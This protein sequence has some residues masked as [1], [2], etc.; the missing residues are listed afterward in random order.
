V[1]RSL[2]ASRAPIPASMHHVTRSLDVRQ[3]GYG[4]ARGRVFYRARGRVAGADAG[5]RNRPTRGVSQPLAGLEHPGALLSRL[6]LLAAAAAR[7]SRSCEAVGTDYFLTL[8]IPIS[9]RAR[10]EDRDDGTA[11]PLRS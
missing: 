3:N 4:E 1:T 9:T 5:N 8:R 7:I 6:R 11:V 2:E 10:F